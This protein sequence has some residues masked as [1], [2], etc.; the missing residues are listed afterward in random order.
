[1]LCCAWPMH[2][3][4]VLHRARR[5]HYFTF[6]LAERSVSEQMQASTYKALCCMSL[7]DGTAGLD[8]FF[9]P[10]LCAQQKFVQF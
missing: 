3:N 6:K 9:C 10:L 7:Q 2:Q 8:S 5:E 4:K 1:M